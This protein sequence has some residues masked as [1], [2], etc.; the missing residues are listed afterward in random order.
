MIPQ[1][2]FSHCLLHNCRFV[3][4][5]QMTAYFLYL[6]PSQDINSPGYRSHQLIFHEQLSLHKVFSFNSSHTN[7]NVLSCN[8]A[9]QLSSRGTG[10]SSLEG[11]YHCLA[12]G[13]VEEEIMRTTCPALGL[14]LPSFFTTFCH[15]DRVVHLE[16]AQGYHAKSLHCT[17]QIGYYQSCLTD[18]SALHHLSF[19]TAH[20]CNF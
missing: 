20:L 3:E 6:I 2:H 16:M 17:A 11:F 7:M 1:L 12:K 10:L 8:L 13:S 4:V 15:E 5:S 14:Q 9:V 18:S 19:R